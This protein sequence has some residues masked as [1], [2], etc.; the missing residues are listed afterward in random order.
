[1][2]VPII[3][4]AIALVSAGAAFATD[5]CNVPMNQWKPREAVAQLAARNGWKVERIRID[6]GC[7]Q[8]Q[9]LDTGGHRIKVKVDPGS[10]ALVEMKIR[11]RDEPARR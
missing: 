10:L 11:Y 2:K 3:A 5:D 1:M 7:Y 6:D 9:G 4:V 8:I